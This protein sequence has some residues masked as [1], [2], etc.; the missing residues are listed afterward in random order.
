MITA[1]ADLESPVKADGCFWKWNHLCTG[2]P[3]SHEAKP[4][5]GQSSRA[6]LAATSTDSHPCPQAGA[7][8]LHAHGAGRQP[9]RRSGQSPHG[10]RS[11]ERRPRRPAPYRKK[12]KR[13]QERRKKIEKEKGEGRAPHLHRRPS[14]VDHHKVAPPPQGR[15]LHR[16]PI[17]GHSRRQP[18]AMVK[19]LAHR[20]RRARSAGRW[21]LAVAA[22][23]WPPPIGRRLAP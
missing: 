23:P 15:T 14:L 21:P 5:Q 17:S 8:R 7:D 20:R 10:R 19:P 12:N 2:H 6:A 4:V 18:L 11:R 16:L 1:T 9:R 13:T 22:A 3:S